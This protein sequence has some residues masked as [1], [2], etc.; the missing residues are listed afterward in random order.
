MRLKGCR[1]LMKTILQV[2]TNIARKTST[3][4]PNVSTN[5]TRWNSFVIWW[6]NSSRYSSW[7]LSMEML[8]NWKTQITRR[9]TTKSKKWGMYFNVIYNLIHHV[10]A[11]PIGNI[12]EQMTLQIRYVTINYYAYPLFFTRPKN[13]MIPSN[14]RPLLSWGCSNIF[15]SRARSGRLPLIRSIIPL[16][17]P[18][19]SDYLHSQ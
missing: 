13:S 9:V 2:F 14:F 18:C 3:I 7:S 4:S 6:P 15:W 16:D 1:S 17:P 11:Q 10:D 8:S 19:I 12:G 5:R